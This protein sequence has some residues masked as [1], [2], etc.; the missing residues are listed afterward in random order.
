MKLTINL[1]THNGNLIGIAEPIVLEVTPEPES[2]RI[3]P[4]DNNL[5]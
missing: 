2:E 5:E 1:I 4:S 3:I